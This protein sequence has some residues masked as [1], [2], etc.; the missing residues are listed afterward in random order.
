MSDIENFIGE[1]IKDTPVSETKVEIQ[2]QD[3]EVLVKF[4]L[5]IRE[6][7]PVERAAAAVKVL[8]SS[9]GFVVHSVDIKPAATENPDIEGETP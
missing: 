8:Y 6:G 2:C 3:E 7:V 1:Y 4:T 5:T 9:L